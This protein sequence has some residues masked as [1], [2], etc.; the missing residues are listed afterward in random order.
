MDLLNFFVY[1]CSVAAMSVQMQESKMGMKLRE[2][3]NHN[4]RNSLLIL[5]GIWLC[6]NL[7]T[8]NKGGKEEI[9]RLEPLLAEGLAQLLG[10]P[11]QANEACRCLYPL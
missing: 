11:W 2:L 5:E 1:R 7:A 10:A 8:V 6:L 4:E 9:S 3:L